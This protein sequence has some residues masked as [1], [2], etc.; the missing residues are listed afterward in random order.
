M[1][2]NISFTYGDYEFTPRPLFSISTEPL[3]TPNG[4]GYGI[5]HSITLEGDLITINDELD[6]GILGVFDKIE[7]LKDALDHDGKLLLVSCDDSPIL[8]GY[9]TIENYNFNNESDNYTRRATYS[10]EFRMPTTIL[11]SGND[12]FNS[13]VHPPFIETCSETR[14]VD[15]QDER[16]PFSWTLADGT[17]E[18][19]GY[20]I[21]ATHTVD[22]TARIAYT[23]DRASNT[24]WEDA[25]AYAT[26]KLGFDNEF[27]NLTGILGLPGAGFTETDVF[28]QFRQISTNKTEGTIQVTET[29]LVTP[30]GTN[31][32]P[33]NAIETFD[34]SS[35]QTDGVVTVNIQGEIQGL[36]EITYIGGMDVTSSKFSAASGYYNI[37]KDRMYDRARTAFSGVAEECFNRP[38]NTTVRSRTVGM[39][40]INGTVSYDY[41][42]DTA[43]DGCITGDCILSQNITIDDTLENDVFASQTVLGRATGPILQDIGTITARV[44][45]VNIELVTLPPTGCSTV[46]EIYAPIPTGQVDSFI[47]VISGD[48]AASYSQVFV[49]SQAQNWNFTAGRYTKSVGFTYTN[50]S[51]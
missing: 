45:T 10:I 6:S 41:Q 23:G 51:T 3:K 48:L 38:L 50:C 34:I 14:D 25:K 26:G 1:A 18:K 12:V 36:A 40:P 4:V 2:T 22:V 21:A 49:S 17:V 43:T 15:F 19:F 42:Y 32:L 39:N 7:I 11:G 37:V 30:S 24:P 5:M 44:R 13:S 27:V 16:L 47:A 20:V 8:S 9:P 35:S 29:F 33:N 31:S 46:A 28:N